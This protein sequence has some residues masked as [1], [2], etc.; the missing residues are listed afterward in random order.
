MK[1]Q[2]HQLK[3][4][5]R[6]YRAD[7]LMTSSKCSLPQASSLRRMPELRKFLQIRKKVAISWRL[8]PAGTGQATPNQVNI[9][10]LQIMSLK[11]SQRDQAGT[12]LEVGS[13]P[14]DSSQIQHATGTFPS[15]P[16]K[17][18]PVRSMAQPQQFPFLPCLFHHTRRY[19]SSCY[20]TWVLTEAG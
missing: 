10:N 17:S 4:I 20:H 11:Q 9:Q 13:C 3:I 5:F 16:Q 19:L 6:A 8:L 12:Q 14:E 15:Q 18:C 1:W 2:Y 7:K